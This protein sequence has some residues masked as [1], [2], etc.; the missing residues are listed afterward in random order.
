MERES[1]ELAKKTYENKFFRSFEILHLP[2]PPQ[3]PE[4]KFIYKRRSSIFRA[5]IPAIAKSRAPAKA[6]SSASSHE[7][8]AEGFGAER[9]LV[10][11]SGGCC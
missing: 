1:E 11:A 2:P 3:T 9:G 6:V 4:P 7:E 10:R 5:R 8:E